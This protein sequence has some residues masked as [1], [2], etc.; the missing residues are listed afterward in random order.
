M[1]AVSEQSVD[2]D[3][4]IKELKEVIQ[5]ENQPD[6]IEVWTDSTSEDIIEHVIKRYHRPLEEELSLLSPYVT[7][8]SRVH[9]ESHEE[10]LKSP[11]IIF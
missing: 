7:K 6:D 2:M 3:V 8:V 4:L 9:G 1:R 11:S 5:K 10:L